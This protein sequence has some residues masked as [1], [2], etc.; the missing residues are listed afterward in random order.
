MSVRDGDVEAARSW[1]SG[2]WR[3][4]VDL[5]WC[6]ST[7][8]TALM[9]AAREG[10]AP[11]VRLLLEANADPTVTDGTVPGAPVTALDYALSGGPPSDEDEDDT[12]TATAGPHPEVA[13]LI[14]T[15]LPQPPE[16]R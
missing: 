15:F 9:W 8:M 16:A 7:G 5:D 12:E 13:E 4:Q 10:R 6:D 11:L 3:E 14:R 1:L 2:D